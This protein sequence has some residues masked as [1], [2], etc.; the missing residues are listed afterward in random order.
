M[1]LIK[2]LGNLIIG[3]ADI[4][5]LK[6]HG[7]FHSEENRLLSTYYSSK[8]SSGT[9]LPGV[10]MMV[11]GHT[12]HGGMSDRLRGIASVYGY[13]KEHGIPFHIHHVTPFRLEE[14]LEPARVNWLTSDQEMTFSR[15]SAQPVILMLHLIPSKLHRLYLNWLFRHKDWQR[16]QYH[17]YSNTLLYDRDYAAN[18][19]ALFRPATRL[20]QAVESECKSI[21]GAYVAMVFRFQQLLGDFSEGDFEVLPAD[22]R[23]PLIEKCLAKMDEIHKRRES[24]TK[25]L[26]T[27]DSTTFLTAAQATFPYVHVIAG[28]MV[29]MDYT[30]NA[31]YQTYM[32]SFVDMLV[33]ARA[34]KIYLLRTGNM[35]KSGFAYRAAAINNVPYEYIDF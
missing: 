2:K 1:K 11:D 29:H 27:S 12:M 13:C 26:V 35:Y 20:E 15:T 34:S 9:F 4:Y 10:V 5:L 14:Y 33:L 24:G 28:K 25:V 18:F 30:A 6:G 8:E 19:Q 17:V 21:G 3:L 16:K 31:D 22:K 32:K 23:K 7:H